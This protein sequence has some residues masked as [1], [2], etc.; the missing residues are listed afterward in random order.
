MS[1]LQE[2]LSIVVCSKSDYPGL[3][4][5]LA[6][7]I[8]LDKD[9]PQIILI[10]S[11]YLES[12]IEKIQKDFSNLKSE[13][14]HVP[15]QGIYH[16][17]N[18]GLSKVKKRLVLFLNGGDK[19]ESP[20]GLKYL[21]SELGESSWGYGEIDIVG[22]DFK[23][24][25]RYRFKYNNFLHRLG[26]KYVPHPATVINAKKAIELGGFDEKYESAADHK[27]LLMFSKSSKPVVVRRQISTFYRGGVSTRKQFEVVNDCKNISYELF[28]Y[29]FKN[30]F[31][32]RLVW[33][34]LFMGKKILKA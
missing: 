20:A 23:N 33:Y 17:Q 31:L 28:G 4:G 12:E 13:L 7:L 19:L 32:D 16:A 5:T 2:E 1:L 15:S 26:L 18:L 27:L 24:R 8:A 14:L 9:L 22:E 30:K 21:V 11:G 10:L 25:K 6:S 29:F 34:F 3:E